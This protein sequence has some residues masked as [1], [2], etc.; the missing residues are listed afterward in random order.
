[1]SKFLKMVRPDQ[2]KNSKKSPEIRHRDLLRN[3]LFLA[4][5]IA[6]FGFFWTKK[7]E[8]HFNIPAALKG[9]N[10]HLRKLRK[11]TKNF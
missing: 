6:V 4:L 1:M 5:K 9:Q 7:G 8:F 2:R 10:K 11:V 3:W